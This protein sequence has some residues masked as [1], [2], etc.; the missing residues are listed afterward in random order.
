MSAL[1][2]VENMPPGMGVSSG[3]SDAGSENGTPGRGSPD[4]RKGMK[5]SGTLPSFPSMDDNKAK[6]KEPELPV[7]LRRRFSDGRV[8]LG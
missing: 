1:N 7:R 3:S 4:V 2:K 5:R 6:A 8:R